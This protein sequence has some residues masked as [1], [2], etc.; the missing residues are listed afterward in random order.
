MYLLL[1]QLKRFS[2]VIDNR[3]KFRDKFLLLTIFVAAKNR[4][5]IFIKTDF[6]IS[7]IDFSMYNSKNIAS[8]DRSKRIFNKMFSINVTLVIVC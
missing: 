8:L 2:I 1:L 4:N 3:A 6:S 5:Y 7:N